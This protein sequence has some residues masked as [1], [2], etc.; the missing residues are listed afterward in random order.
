MYHTITHYLTLVPRHILRSLY[1][2]LSLTTYLLYPPRYLIPT[3]YDMIVSN[4][5]RLDQFLLLV[6]FSPCLLV[7]D[8]CWLAWRSFDLTPVICIVYHIYHIYLIS[9]IIAICW[10][11][12]L[13]QGHR[14]WGMHAHCAVWILRESG[15]RYQES[16]ISGLSTSRKSRKCRIR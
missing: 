6:S 13:A 8:T 4:S 7:Y 16:G 12:T 10:P 5:V 3:T 15:I 2:W 1:C 11:V 9:Y 14:P